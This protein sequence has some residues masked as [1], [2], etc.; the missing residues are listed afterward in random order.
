MNYQIKI[1]CIQLSN[2]RLLTGTFGRE[3]QLF[4]LVYVI[5]AAS[6]HV[7]YIW[8]Y[9]RLEVSMFH[10][11]GKKESGVTSSAK[12]VSMKIARTGTSVW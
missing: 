8:T 5:K 12:P 1:L 4:A 6:R 11:T 3:M 7:K 2:I 10:P 9:V